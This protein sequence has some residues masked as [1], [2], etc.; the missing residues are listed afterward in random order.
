[1]LKQYKHE[2]LMALFLI[3][4][5]LAGTYVMYQINTINY[6]EVIYGLK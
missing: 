5:I 4:V 6:Y 2:L 1:M 3:S